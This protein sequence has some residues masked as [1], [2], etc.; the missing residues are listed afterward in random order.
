MSRFSRMVK[1][2]KKATENPKN[3]KDDNCFQYA[4]AVPLNHQ[5]IENNP[6]RISK[7]KPFINKYNW[8]GKNFPSHEEDWNN[9]EKNNKLISLN[10]LFVP[11]NAKQVRH[12]Y[13][14]KYN[15][16]REN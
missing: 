9:F 7:I 2:I 14:S 16:D 15:S 1:K 6:E 12:P 4:I 8:E 3:K 11:Q 10:V 5:N 13:L